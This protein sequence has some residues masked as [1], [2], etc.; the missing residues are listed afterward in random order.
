MQVYNLGVG[1]GSSVLDVIGAFPQACG[2]PI[3]YAVEAR[4]PGDVAELVAD[5]AAVER[6]W[7]WHPTRDLAEVCRD[8]WRFQR[9]NPHGS[10]YRTV[11]VAG[12]GAAQVRVA[13]ARHASAGGPAGP[14][15]RRGP[16]RHERVLTLLRGAGFDEAATADVFRAF[17]AW[18]LGYVSV[19]LRPVVDQPG[20]DRPGLPPRA[21]PAVRE[22]AADAAQD[23]GGARRAG[24]PGGPRGRAGRPARR[25]L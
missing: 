2:R 6:A 4:R 14:A 18:L 21:A 24:R 25:L 3:P 15:A 10:R 23:G 8:A 7:G 16:A 19:E 13:A 9:L 20:R 22:G 12:P 5:A 17:T 1:A 11:E